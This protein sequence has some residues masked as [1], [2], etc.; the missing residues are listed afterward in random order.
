MAAWLIIHNVPIDW[1]IFRYDLKG[2]YKKGIASPSYTKT[3]KKI[4][5]LS[6]VIFFLLLICSVFLPLPLGTA[7]FYTGLAIFLIVGW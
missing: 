7:W 3:E 2:L 5:A 1:L 6:T 4:N